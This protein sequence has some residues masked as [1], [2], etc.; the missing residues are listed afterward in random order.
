M[1]DYPERESRDL[2]GLEYLATNEEENEIFYRMVQTSE[3]QEHRRVMNTLQHGYY[4]IS[5]PVASGLL[6]ANAQAEV[7]ANLACVK[8]ARKI[9]C[10]VLGH[11]SPM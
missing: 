6:N 8:V 2:F 7:D 3:W 10:A 9:I 11:T 1:T 5:N 4:D